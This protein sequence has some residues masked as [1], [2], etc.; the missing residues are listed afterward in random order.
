MTNRM[1]AR[2]GWGAAAASACLLMAGC[3]V[4]PGGGSDGAPTQ[5]SGALLVE[6]MVRSDV[7]TAA[8]IEVDVDARD[9]PQ[10]SDDENVSLPFSQQFEVSTSVPFPL[11]GVSVEA[12]AAPDATWIEC[13]VLLDGEVIVEDRA[14]GSEATADCSKE[15]RVGPQ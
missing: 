7:N 1:V 12:T 3:G 11:S 9:D 6:I 4:P 2:A 14:E 15:L 13:Q 8:R 5:T 10:Q